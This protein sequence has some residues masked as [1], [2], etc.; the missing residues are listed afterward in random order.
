MEWK[1]KEL[2]IDSFLK[3]DANLTIEEKLNKYGSDG[4]ELA[5]IIQKPQVGVGWLSKGDS[6]VIILKK[7]VTV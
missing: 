3:S 6:D 5:C 4:W 2:P 7:S 1:Y